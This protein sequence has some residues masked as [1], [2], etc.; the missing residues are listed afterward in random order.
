MGTAPQRGGPGIGSRPTAPPGPPPPCSPPPLLVQ[1]QSHTTVLKMRSTVT[2]QVPDIQQGRMQEGD[3]NDSQPTPHGHA[4]PPQPAAHHPLLAEHPSPSGLDRQH[5]SLQQRLHHRLSAAARRLFRFW[6][7]AHRHSL[8]CVGSAAAG[9]QQDV[10]KLRALQGEKQT[11]TRMNGAPAVLSWAWRGLWTAQRSGCS[12][13]EHAGRSGWE[14]LGG[15]PC[16]F[17]CSSQSSAQTLQTSAAIAHLHRE[18]QHAGRLHSN[19]L[20][21]LL[22]IVGGHR[23]RQQAQWRAKCSAEGATPGHTCKVG[24]GCV[25]HTWAAP[26]FCRAQRIACHV[27]WPALALCETTCLQT[28]CTAA[29][30]A[31]LGPAHAP[32]QTPAIIT[33]AY[34]QRLLLI[35]GLAGV[36]VAPVGHAVVHLQTGVTRKPID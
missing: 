22:P 6:Q 35:G 9:G 28:A 8:G 33:S 13:Q 20:Q 16:K 29:Q 19:R 36:Q 25:P 3:S 17:M 5:A 26:Q 27:A 10:Q 14:Q 21:I 31:R 18:L 15:A 23:C 30:H 32:A 12:W 24:R 34:L 2:A 1:R 7:L 11:G 4:A